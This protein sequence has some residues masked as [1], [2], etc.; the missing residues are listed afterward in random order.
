MLDHQNI[1]IPDFR[2]II[3]HTTLLAGGQHQ[4]LSAI[5]MGKKTQKMLLKE[6]CMWFPHF[7]VC[8]P[9]Y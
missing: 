9:K 6:I 2:T 3:G 1:L 7:V 8:P 5:G 4:V